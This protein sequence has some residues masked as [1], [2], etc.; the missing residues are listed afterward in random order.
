MCNAENGRVN[1]LL[2]KNIGASSSTRSVRVD[3]GEV[4]E[5]ARYN[6]QGRP[7]KKNEKGIQVIVYSNYITKT[8]IIE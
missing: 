1:Y 3:D 6:L 2:S 7:V 4:K 5:V 8:I